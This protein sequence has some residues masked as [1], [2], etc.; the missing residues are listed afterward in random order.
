MLPGICGGI[1]PLG[2]GPIMPGLHP[3]GAGCAAI[4]DVATIAA[5]TIADKVAVVAD[6][7]G[8]I[9]VPLIDMSP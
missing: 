8:V 5:S 4:G 7:N 9:A 3:W 6:L 2:P 1:W